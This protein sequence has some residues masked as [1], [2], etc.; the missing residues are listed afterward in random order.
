MMNRFETFLDAAMHILLLKQPLFKT[1]RQFENLVF[2]IL[3]TRKNI[4]LIARTPFLPEEAN[5]FL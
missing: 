4:R 2:V 1:L 3:S 5:S